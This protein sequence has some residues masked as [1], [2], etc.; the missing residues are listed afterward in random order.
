M[1]REVNMACGHI[2]KQL[3]YTGTGATKKKMAFAT[4]W[5]HTVIFKQDKF[6]TN[7][8][9]KP[10][11]WRSSCRMTFKMV[12][13]STNFTSGM[14]TLEIT[15][16]F[17]PGYWIQISPRKNQSRITMD[18]GT[19]FV[20]SG[21]NTYNYMYFLIYFHAHN[22]YVKPGPFGFISIQNKTPWKWLLLVFVCTKKKRFTARKSKTNVDVACLYHLW[23]RVSAN[24]GT[25]RQASLKYKTYIYHLTHTSI[26]MY[27]TV[28]IYICMLYSLKDI[29]IIFLYPI[30]YINQPA[31][32]NSST[33][34]CN[35][36]DGG[37]R[38]TE[39]FQ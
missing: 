29:Y 23:S 35:S 31:S 9:C 12:F 24:E 22:L 21:P 36:E 8:T 16:K 25:R 18:Y 7:D 38:C 10:W 1:T 17:R 19:I 26:S 28:Y 11:I 30:P 5:G 39:A 14:G 37:W 13:F 34:I 32:E 3:Q 15:F 33:P 4:L 27:V 2:E 20:Y 6:E